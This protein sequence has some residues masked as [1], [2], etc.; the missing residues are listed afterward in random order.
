MQILVFSQEKTEPFMRDDVQVL[1][2]SRISAT[3]V[4][5][6]VKDPSL[7]TNIDCGDVDETAKSID[8]CYFDYVKNSTD[9]GPCTLIVS[10]DMKKKCLNS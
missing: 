1:C 10:E 9:K 6:D 5:I 8:A 7:C 2:S 3:A 4:A